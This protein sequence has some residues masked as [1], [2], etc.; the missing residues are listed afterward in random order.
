MLLTTT[1][2]GEHDA[3]PRVWFAGLP[4]PAPGLCDRPTVRDDQG[5][6]WQ[7]GRDGQ[8]HTTDGRHHQSWPQLRQRSDLTELHPGEVTEFI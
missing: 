3:A 7:P 6:M 4:A 8:W 1:P 2:P 5:H